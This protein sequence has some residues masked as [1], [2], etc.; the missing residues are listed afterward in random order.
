MAV[1]GAVSALALERGHILINL[2]LA[3]RGTRFYP[4]GGQES[5][6]AR[7]VIEQCVLLG[8]IK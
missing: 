5:E 2:L 1:R 4:R 8:F 7:V 6:A 3:L